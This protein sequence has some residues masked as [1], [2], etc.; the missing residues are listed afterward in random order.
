MEVEKAIEEISQGKV[1]ERRLTQRVTEVR[2]MMRGCANESRLC[3]RLA[4]AVKAA[5]RREL[6]GGRRDIGDLKQQDAVDELEILARTNEQLTSVLDRQSDSLVLLDNSSAALKRV[7]DEYSNV[8][9]TLDV[10]RKVLN[11][12]WDKRK[13]D[14]FWLM[15]ACSYFALVAAYIV[16]SRVFGIF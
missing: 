8:M 6:A 15:A 1:P 3:S 4:D 14:D 12:L 16:S 11:R 9:S 7:H 13:A 5:K 2:G 10:T